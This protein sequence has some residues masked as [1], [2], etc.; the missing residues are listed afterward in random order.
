M[1]LLPKSRASMD[2]APGRPSPKRRRGPPDLGDQP[3]DYTGLAAGG[4]DS[5]ISLR[6][7]KSENT[8]AQ[9]EGVKERPMTKNELNRF[10]AVLTARVAELERVTRHHDA[11][12][13][14]RRADQ[15]EE[16]QAASQRALAVC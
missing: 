16:I 3:A 6:R 15:L 10:R 12:I 11:I 2:Q 4:N 8:F 9:E 5:T 14:E 1:R 7:T 13:V